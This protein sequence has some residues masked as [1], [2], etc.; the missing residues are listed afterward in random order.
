[1]RLLS[2]PELYALILN[3]FVVHLMTCIGLYIRAHKVELLTHT[4]LLIAT[5]LFTGV[6]FLAYFEMEKYIIFFI[7]VSNVSI[8][9]PS[10]VIVLRRFLR[11]IRRG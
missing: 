4:S 9:L 1:M 7:A 5:T 10:A 6:W 2:L 3:S 8:G 11:V